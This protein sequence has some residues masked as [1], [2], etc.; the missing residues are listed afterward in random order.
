MRK[1]LEFVLYTIAQCLQKSIHKIKKNLNKS[2][3]LIEF[4]EGTL[5]F[6]KKKYNYSPLAYKYNKCIGATS[7]TGSPDKYG[8]RL[9]S[10]L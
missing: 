10:T 6:K 8:K 2:G 4:A 3:K 1:L 9:V 7:T 5:Q